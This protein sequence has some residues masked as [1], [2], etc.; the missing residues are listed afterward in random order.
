MKRKM[1]LAALAASLLATMLLVACSGQNANQSK[2]A[3]GKFYRDVS[4]NIVAEYG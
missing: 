3:A 4:I 1:Q 2:T